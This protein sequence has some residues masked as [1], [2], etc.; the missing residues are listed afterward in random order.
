MRVATLDRRV[1]FQSKPAADA[2]GAR[3]PV[4]GS[5]I[6]AWADVIT[7][8]AE[9]VPIPQE[10]AEGE[11]VGLVQ[12]RNRSRLRIRYRTDIDAAMRV[13][14]QGRTLQIISGPSEVGRRQYLEMVLEEYSTQGGA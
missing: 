14:Y 9:L 12:S 6:G 2:P 7:V 13:Q 3:D 5:E 11:R 4:F 1:T 8:W 10:R